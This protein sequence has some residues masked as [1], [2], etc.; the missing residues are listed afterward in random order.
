MADNPHTISLKDAAILT[1]RW[2]EN[3]P[4]GGFKAGRFDRIA[5]DTLLGNP[6]CAGIRIYMGMSLPGATENPSL[7]NFVMI[8]TDAEGN[9]ITGSGTASR[10]AD[11]DA[12]EADGDPQE[13]STVCPPYCSLTGPLNGGDTPS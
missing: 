8:G 3:M 11:G 2:R 6:E 1:A 4:P 7:W 12:G 10:G 9:D 5:F 13:M